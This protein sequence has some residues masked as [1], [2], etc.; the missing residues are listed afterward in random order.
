MLRDKIFFKVFWAAVKI[1]GLQPHLIGRKHKIRAFLCFFSLTG[2]I[3]VLSI[4]ALLK[5]ENIDDRLS[6]LQIFPSLIAFILECMNFLL[7][8]KKIE[9]VFNRLDELFVEVNGEEFRE[10]GFSLFTINYA[11]NAINLLISLIADLKK[12]YPSSIKLCS[13]FLEL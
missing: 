11:V 13:I 8:S 4:V 9:K 10:R 3:S 12:I 2:L 6:G 5:T 7:N 1:F